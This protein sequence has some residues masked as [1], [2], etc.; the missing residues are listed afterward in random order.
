MILS[1]GAPNDGFLLNTLK[2]LLRLSRVIFDILKSIL[3]VALKFLSFRSSDQLGF[4]QIIVIENKKKNVNSLVAKRYSF[5]GPEYSFF[6][7]WFILARPFFYYNLPPMNIRSWGLTWLSYCLY[8]NL[9]AYFSH[10]YCITV[11]TQTACLPYL[12]TAY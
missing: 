7:Y 1:H 6:L 3:S 10:K 11:R 8:F 12:E 4:L 5:V 2:A 9:F